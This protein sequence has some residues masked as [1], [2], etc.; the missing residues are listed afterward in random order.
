MSN[1]HKEAKSKDAFIVFSD[2]V[3]HF[4]EKHS[5]AFIV[6]VG[7]VTAISLAYVGWDWLSEKQQKA[8]FQA[9]YQTE[10]QL[11]RLEIQKEEAEVEKQEAL[12]EFYKKAKK[13]NRKK[14]G[15][16]KKSPEVARWN[17]KI[18]QIEKS[19]EQ[20]KK[21][22]VPKYKSF[23]KKYQ[24]RSAAAVALLNVAREF[25]KEKQWKPLRDVLRNNPVKP[26][27]LFYAPLRLKLAQA[28]WEEK[29]PQGALKIL[30][31]LLS[32]GK[33]SYIHAP[34][35]LQQALIVLSQGQ[36]DR[37]RAIYEKIY[38]NFP[39][40]RS[41]N[42]A[43]ANLRLLQIKKLS[44]RGVASSEE[45]SQQASTS[46]SLKNRIWVA[47]GNQ[48]LQCQ[49]GTGIPLEKMAHELS[50]TKIFS[51][52]VVHET[53]VRIQLCGEPQGQLN[54]YLISQSDLDLA[55]KRGFKTWLPAQ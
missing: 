17:K 40:T 19:I 20:E 4:V 1:A 33:Y 27:S 32:N 49:P 15:D 10:G 3:I 30:E 35:Y 31:A 7:G 23:I 55:L 16:P 8:A 48:S 34:A 47:K 25:E 52:Q 22:L 44:Q 2:R 6:G 41:A 43:R 14:L 42:T 39:K 5:V 50:F 26:D 18:K 21:N 13:E 11:K 28:E 53:S 45:V 38:K 9:L 29:N 46:L 51:S 54:A 37:A 12:R 24:G 36:R